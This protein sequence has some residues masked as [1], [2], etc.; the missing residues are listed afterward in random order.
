M[1]EKQLQ[2]PRRQPILLTMVSGPAK[3]TP[4]QQE[5]P[6]VL[7]TFKEVVQWALNWPRA[8][9][10]FSSLARSWSE[11]ASK[12]SYSVGMFKYLRSP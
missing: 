6:V 1:P 9:S 10:V 8:H 7:T 2:Q 12:G 4:G 5:A 11:L 3:H